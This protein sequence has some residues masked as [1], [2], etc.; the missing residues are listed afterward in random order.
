MI[1]GEKLPGQFE[2]GFGSTG[3]GIVKGH[4]FAVTGRLGQPN[5][6]WNYGVIE[7]FA[8]VL[9]ESLCHLLGQIGAVIVHGEQNT[10][11]RDVWIVGGA[12]A[13]KRGDELRDALES[14]VLGLHGDNEGV[15]GGQD[16]ESKQ[17][18]GRGAIQNDQV[19]TVLD[20]GQGLAQ[21]E[22]AVARR[23]EFDVGARQVLRPGQKEQQLEFPWG[24]LPAQRG[25]RP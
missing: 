11:N 25:S 9:A 6:A 2:V 16:V 24:E 3:A 4:G 23:S 19:K 10:F 22:G 1:T 5:V 13:F 7:P 15:C 18:K 14:E 21:A 12:N 17:V 20:R 8:E